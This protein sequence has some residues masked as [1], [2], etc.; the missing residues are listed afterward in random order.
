MDSIK[1]KPWNLGIF[2]VGT[3]FVVISFYTGDL[4][5]FL[6]GLAAEIYGFSKH[7]MESVKAGDKA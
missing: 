1:R 7:Y 6:I 3:G 2:F 5:I 4:A